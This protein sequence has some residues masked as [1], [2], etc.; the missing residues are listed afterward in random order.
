MAAQSPLLGLYLLFCS[1]QCWSLQ[2][3]P[4]ESAAVER[5]LLKRILLSK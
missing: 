4:I 2:W 5:N 1:V 3:Q